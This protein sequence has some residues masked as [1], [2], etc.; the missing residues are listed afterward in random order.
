[1]NPISDRI[2][3]LRA[4]MSKHGL[5]A[6]FVPT[7]DFHMSEYVDA[8]FKARKY[9]TG[10]SGSAGQLVVTPEEAALWVDSRYFIQAALQTEGT[11]VALMK[12]GEEGVPTL[13]EYLADK[14]PE[15]SALG[16]DGRCVSAKWAM[17]TEQL[18]SSKKIELMPSLDLVGEIWE[19]RPP[20]PVGRAWVLDD[21]YTGRSAS[22]KLDAV[23]RAMAEYDANAHV[24]TSLDDIAWLL[25]LR[26]T[27]IPCNPVVISYL[28][29]EADCA[30]LFADRAKFDAGTAEYLEKLG[31]RVLPYND[32]YDFSSK[33]DEGDAVLLSSE[34]VNYALYDI[35]AED[36]IVIDAENPE[37]LAKAVKNPVETEHIREAHIKDGLAVTRFM[38]WV[39][40]N[41][42]KLPMDE[43][44]AGA[45]LD[46]LRLKT[47]GNLGLSFDTICAYGE[48]AALPHYS[49]TAE[50]NVPVEP[51]GF[52]LV[53]SGG[54]YYEGTTDIT[55]TIAVGPLTDEERAHF[56]L[57][58]RG[59]LSL[60]FAR[61]PY[62]CRGANLDA[63]CRE[64]LWN[65]GLDFKHG[66]GHGVG[67]LLNV[68]E[69]PNSF[70]WRI[71]D[72]KVDS[73]VLEEGMLTS[74]EP[75][76]YFEGSHGIRTEN[77]ILCRKGEK[78]DSVQYM[79]FETVTCAPIDLDA[80]DPSLLN[81][82]ER[83]QLNAYH[84]FVFEKL[85][86]LM[87]RDEREWLRRY[88][89]SI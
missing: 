22:D 64:P 67:Y 1:M 81:E 3:R 60:A 56:A 19:D 38:K 46:S 72:D 20:L 2:A 26:G 77:L 10:F 15:G 43:L 17:K 83:K 63:L 12:M 39:K 31:V 78:T 86:P 57:V 65:A 82:T 44:S 73:C 87:D 50:S 6:Y 40:D 4:L 53:D 33:F 48:H 9:M 42:G 30:F 47:E 55:R 84:A 7:D 34:R 51:R 49:A 59:M 27:D 80:I 52:L 24:L 36:A 70:R 11:P 5:A 28:I 74:D 32:I 76:L 45:Y 41:I 37:R 21:K 66:T 8:H 68:H 14:L 75:G 71:A 18:L 85:A 69:G 16:F 29:V 62:G 89:R 58:L 23:R 79:Y 35:L 61:F 88:T 54:Q 25:N 13:A